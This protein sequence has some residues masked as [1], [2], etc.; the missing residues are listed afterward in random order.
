MKSV[1]PA[2]TNDRLWTLLAYRLALFLSD[3]AWRDVSKLALDPRTRSLSDQL[4]RAVGSIGANIAEGY[5][6]STGGNRTRH[7]EYALGSAR[8]SREWYY[9]SSYVLGMRVTEHRLNLLTRIIQLLI[10]Y[11]PEQRKT[12]LR[13]ES[14]HYEVE[15]SAPISSPA[16]AFDAALTDLIS[17][18]PMPVEEDS[19]I[20]PTPDSL[21]PTPHSRTLE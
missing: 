4:Y 1:P 10:G 5:S 9:R 17:Q 8:E 16:I 15:R 13:E 2:I 14:V 3:I 21:L 19:P 12:S 11:I 18:V 7:F 20:R 6:Y